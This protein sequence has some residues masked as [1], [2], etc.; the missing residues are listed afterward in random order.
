MLRRSTF[1]TCLLVL[2]ACPLSGCK[3]STSSLQGSVREWLSK[4]PVGG[5]TVIAS[6]STDIV[7][8]KPYTRIETKTS[9]DGT[10][11]LKGLLPHRKYTIRVEA[12]GLA[13]H[14][15][16]RATPAAGLTRE[17]ETIDG[18]YCPSERGVYGWDSRTNLFP[19]S[20]A[21]PDN[22]DSNGKPLLF[23]HPDRFATF[24]SVL[25]FKDL[26]DKI[27]YLYPGFTILLRT[28]GSRSSLYLFPL[29]LLP[30]S[31]VQG[32]VWP[33]AFYVSVAAVGH[34]DDLEELPWTSIRHKED[35]WP[36][37][38]LPHTRT[39]VHIAESTAWAQ[40]EFY[41]PVFSVKDGPDRI[42]VF[43]IT[44]IEDIPGELFVLSTENSMREHYQ[45]LLFD[46]F[47]FRFGSRS[48][49]EDPSPSPRTSSIA[50]THTEGS[51]NIAGHFWTKLVVRKTQA[52]WK[53]QEKSDV[54]VPEATVVILFFVRKDGTL[55]G[56]P[57]IYRGS[58]H[59]A[60]IQSCFR[61]IQESAP[62]PP[63][64][65]DFSGAEAQVGLTFYAYPKQQ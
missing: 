40:K 62:F 19:L 54:G 59:P 18:I 31:R 8:E 57:E 12:T 53:V 2:L 33:K 35:Y 60:L 24:Y 26:P 32:S 46:V 37:L 22:T 29:S 61:A 20:R 25:Y 48:A 51:H 44:S 11:T 10:F 9:S 36:E 49:I 47:P 15:E 58:N 28:N 42:F 3:A 56:E 21:T 41:V 17:I 63:L 65:D 52:K 6:C 5:A 38:R 4:R 30:Q 45:P 23:R 27:P 55:K 43:R 16:V 13:F 1:L 34:L 14:S 7:Q 39:R 64:P 50:Y